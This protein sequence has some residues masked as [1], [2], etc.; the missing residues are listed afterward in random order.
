[1]G[2]IND[3]LPYLNLRDGEEILFVKHFDGGMPIKWLKKYHEPEKFPEHLIKIKKDYYE[4][5]QFDI[6][7]NFRMIKFG[8]N[9]IYMEEDN[10][11]PFSEIFHHENL[12]L[13]VN[14]EDIDDFDVQFELVQGGGGMGFKFFGKGRLKV[15]KNPLHFTGYNYEEYCQVKDIVVNLLKFDRQEIDKNED[16]KIQN[17]IKK[18]VKISVELYLGLLIIGL[19]MVPFIIQ[20]DVQNLLELILFLPF[21]SLYIVYFLFF[22]LFNI[23]T[24][25]ILL[26]KYKEKKFFT[27]MKIDY[28][29]Y[30]G[31]AYTASFFGL[32]IGVLMGY[33]G[34][35]SIM[36]SKLVA[37]LISVGFW[38][39]VLVLAYGFALLYYRKKKKKEK[40]AN[41]KEF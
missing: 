24:H 2:D 30:L 11:T 34:L 7:T 38:A 16:M 13:W 20:S 39:I 15:K 28:A 8:I 12:Y 21:I 9:Y 4:F 22:L 10:I 31:P 17:I 3:V 33:G 25:W 36:D 41:D 40:K 32:G 18:S 27:L 23:I 14:L 19:C 5:D 35:S 6:I 1:M 37:L 26:K 29:W